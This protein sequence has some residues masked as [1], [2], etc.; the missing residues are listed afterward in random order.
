M[1]VQAVVYGIVDAL[2][3]LGCYSLLHALWGDWT[4]FSV[5]MLMAVFIIYIFGIATW[6]AIFKDRR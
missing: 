4:M 5:G 1:D 6:Q 2:V 3:V